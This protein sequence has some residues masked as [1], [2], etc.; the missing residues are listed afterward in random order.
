[1]LDFVTDSF[2]FKG[3]RGG[4]L[5]QFFVMVMWYWVTQEFLFFLESCQNQMFWSVVTSWKNVPSVAC[6][7]NE[8]TYVKV[9]MELCIGFALWIM[10]L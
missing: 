6:R 1:M 7:C 3:V 10:M 2:F 9:V 8:L 4:D 5:K